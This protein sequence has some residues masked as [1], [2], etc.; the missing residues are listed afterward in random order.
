MLVADF[1]PKVT[2]DSLIMQ[3]QTDEMGWSFGIGI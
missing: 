3:L 2:S 1:L